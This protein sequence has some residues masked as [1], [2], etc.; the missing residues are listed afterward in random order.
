MANAL[1][2]G[3][4]SR[5][6]GRKPTGP[7]RPERPDLVARCPFCGSRAKPTPT[8]QCPSCRSDLQR[9][10]EGAQNPDPIGSPIA[11]P[12]DAPLA[13]AIAAAFAAPR[14]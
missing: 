11:A 14:P 1:L 7:D 8:G 4:S 9:K 5:R 3:S 10:V 2:G 12:L 13:A 6:A